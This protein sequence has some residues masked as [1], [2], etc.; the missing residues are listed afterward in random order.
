M[1][2]TIDGIG[3]ELRDPKGVTDDRHL[4]FAEL[5]FTRQE[6]P[7]ERRLDAEDLEVVGR[8]QARL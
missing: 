4:M 5:I 1:R 8:H 3:A 7:A 6:G 2:L